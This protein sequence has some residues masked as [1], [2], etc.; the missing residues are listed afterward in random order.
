M[1]IELYTI[2]HCNQKE[3]IKEFLRKNN[4]P[5]KEKVV[6]NDQVKTEL[7]RTAS[8]LPYSKESFLKI[9]YSHGIHV[10]RGFND[11]AL[12]QLLEHIKKYNPK[13]II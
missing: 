7:K 2:P 6:D 12:N 5:F 9:T 8:Y 4:L 11:F 1:K 10:I 3:L 13:I